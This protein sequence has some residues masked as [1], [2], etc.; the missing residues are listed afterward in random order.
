[1]ADAAVAA[2]VA[3]PMLLTSDILEGTVAAKKFDALIQWVKDFIL[4]IIL[5]GLGVLF[6]A[7]F[8]MESI[9]ACGRKCWVQCRNLFRGSRP[10]DTIDVSEPNA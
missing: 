5:G 7:L 9:K 3:S 8:I 10:K 2:G 1:M 4:A 6:A